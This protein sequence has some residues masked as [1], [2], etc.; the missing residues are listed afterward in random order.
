MSRNYTQYTH[1][2]LTMGI[3]GN[4]SI[5]CE[6]H[7]KL[8]PVGLDGLVTHECLE[9]FHNIRET[10]VKTAPENIDFKFTVRRDSAL[11]FMDADRLL[12][13][14]YNWWA[15]SEHTPAKMPDSIH[16]RTAVY[17]ATKDMVYKKKEQ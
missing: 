4:R 2:Q 15:K 16:T 3:D 7:D 5:Y 13:E 11:D 8:F 12:A 14:W 17:L 10:T 1:G 9:G 6:P